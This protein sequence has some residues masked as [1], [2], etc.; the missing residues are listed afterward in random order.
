[1]FLVFIQFGLSHFKGR[2]MY[3][4]CIQSPLNPDLPF[5]SSLPSLYKFC[6]TLMNSNYCMY[7]CMYVSNTW[8][9]MKNTELSTQLIPVFS[10]TLTINNDYSP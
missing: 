9:D 8:I 6:F 5:N 7:L 3:V 10:R 4:S 1:M 2:P